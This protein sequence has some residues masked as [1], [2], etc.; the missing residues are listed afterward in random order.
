[1]QHDHKT[2][3]QPA[4]SRRIR[5][6][7]RSLQF[8]R[9]Q[10]TR[11]MQLAGHV[12]TR[13]DWQLFLERLFLL[14]GATL[15]VVGIMSFFAFN[16]AQLHYYAK[17]AIPQ[18]LLLAGVTIAAL[19]GLDTASG[20]VALLGAAV[21]VGVSLAMYGQTYQTGADPYGLF[22]GWALLIMLWVA[23]SRMPGMWLLLMV[24]LNLTLI[25]Y[26]AQVLHPPRWE[27]WSDAGPLL[28]IVGRLF[29]FGLAQ[30]L[31]VLNAAAVLVWELLALH[32][33]GWMQS[34]GLPRMLGVLSLVFILANVLSLIFASDAEFNERF[35]WLSPV[36]YVAA[37][38]VGLWF[39]QSRQQDLFMLAVLLLSAIVVITSLVIRGMIGARVDF[40]IATPLFIGLLILGQLYAA[41]AWMR[42]IR[43]KWRAAA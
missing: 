6:L 21:M 8:T 7:A 32:S 2:L 18:V 42:V 26:W 28:M 14:G 35:F 5:Y 24:L 10:F 9:E 37:S 34:R 11:A 15:L 33:T 38:I 23:I 36:V 19:R 41:V 29:D 13:Q 30:W 25:L 39:Y 22:L 12:P 4:T 3:E 17:L 43:V 20:R 40:D 1:M 27:L 16:W 31:F